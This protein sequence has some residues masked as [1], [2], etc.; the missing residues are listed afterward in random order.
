MAIW[1]KEIINAD[2]G[3]KIRSEYRKL[4]SVG[5]SDEEAENLIVDYFRGQLLDDKLTMG[6]FWM[7]LALY[8]WEFGRLTENADRNA[9]QWACFPWDNIS[10]TALETLVNT[11]DAPLPP[12]KKVRI[13]SYV[14]HC[15]WPVGS[16]LAYRIISAK[17]PYVTESP[18]YEKYVLLRII[19]I[20]KIPVTRLAPND[21]WNERMLVGLYHWIGDSIPDPKIIDDLQFTAISVQE[22]SLPVSAFCNTP[23][24]QK[25][26]QTPQFQQIL[27]LTTQPRIETCCDLDWSCVRGIKSKDVFTYLGCDPSFAQEVSPFFK[28]GITDY[29]MSHSIPFDAVLVNRFSQLAKESAKTGDDSL[30]G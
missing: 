28:T 3:E 9:R 20:K 7:A 8:E 15:P 6:R 16:L 5:K 19:Q 10:K 1:K 26:A 30:F 22:P 18:F 12:K 11:L 17:H 27:A 24:I 13:P 2:L 25:V 4:L 29:A 14:S 21:A 23:T